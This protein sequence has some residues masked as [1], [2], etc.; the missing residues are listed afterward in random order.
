M[1]NE[2]VGVAREEDGRL[3]ITTV[4]GAQ[5][6]AVYGPYTA[7]DEG[8]YAVEFTIRANGAI[9]DGAVCAAIDVSC[10]FGRQVVAVRQI[11]AEELTAGRARFALPFTLDHQSVVEFRVFVTG[12]AE[13]TIE[14]RRSVKS[15][16]PGDDPAS[17]FAGAG[18]PDPV[19]SPSRFF[20]EN[21][22]LFTTIYEAGFDIE[23]RG[24]D[25]LLSIDGICVYARCSDD[26]M[27]LRGV[28]LE[29]EYNLLAPRETCFIDVGMNIGLVTLLA[30]SRDFVREVHSFEPFA[31]TYRRAVDNIALNPAAAA[32][33]RAHCV[34]LGDRDETARFRIAGTVDSG[35]LQT[36]D[37][38][39]GALVELVLKD[40]A[41]TL[42]PIIAAARG[43]GLAVIAKIDCEGAEYQ[44]F[45][46]LLNAGL[47]PQIDAFMVETHTVAGRSYKDDL[48]APL[49]R[50]GFVI[51]DRTPR[52]TNGNG[53]F[54]AARIG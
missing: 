53:F 7:L 11:V 36:R 50:A 54:Y 47:L 37:M 33:V 3:S 24:E 31:A 19:S 27:F 52:T 45:A 16:R 30:A 44:I 29:S 6:H 2:K 14:D 41:A 13:L 46:S 42:G 5:G 35:S 25:A 39:E 48:F 8:S 49:R 22:H 34:G 4:L 17:L 12:L 43:G 38:G 23:I 26:F 20:A 18:Y 10:N 21:Q 1:L 51:F 15:L 9:T 32:K 40:A 28:F